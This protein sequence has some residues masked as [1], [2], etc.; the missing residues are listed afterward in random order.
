MTIKKF[1]SGSLAFLLLAG[2]ALAGCGPREQPS[3]IVTGKV[4]SEGKPVTSGR[5]VFSSEEQGINR[6]INLQADG[7]FQSTASLPTG[8]YRVYLLPPDQGDVPPGLPGEQKI[9]KLENVPQKYQSEKSTDLTVTI[10][11]GGNNL[12]LDLKP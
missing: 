3:G 4:E 12:T 5:V 7:T 1:R 2:F 9:P 11:K 8:N 10:E 6:S